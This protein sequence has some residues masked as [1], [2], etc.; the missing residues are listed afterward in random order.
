MTLSSFPTPAWYEEQIT[1]AVPAHPA[2]TVLAVEHPAIVVMV[3]RIAELG[4]SV[5]AMPPLNADSTPMPL[6]KSVP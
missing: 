3:R 2:Q 1:H 6:E 5:N 4:A